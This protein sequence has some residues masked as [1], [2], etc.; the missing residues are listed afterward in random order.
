M[1]DCS[2]TSSSFQEWASIIVCS[3]LLSYEKTSAIVEDLFA[4]TRSY[5]SLEEDLRISTLKS[6][7]LTTTRGEEMG[8]IGKMD[9][10]QE[11]KERVTY[12]KAEASRKMAQNGSRTPKQAKDRIYS[13]IFPTRRICTRSNK[14]RST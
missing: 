5:N 1:E 3:L 14:W 13:W 12:W 6:I 8:F 11:Q 10:D 4:K 7:A 9:G 2:K